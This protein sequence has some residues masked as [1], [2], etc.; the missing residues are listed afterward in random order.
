MKTKDTGKII[1]MW[2]AWAKKQGVLLNPDFD[3]EKKAKLYLKTNGKCFCDPKRKGPCLQS[4]EEI[5]K[6]NACLCS[7]FV[8]K[9][10]KKEGLKNIGK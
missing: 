10:F 9:K 5:K 6:H 8:N 7:L 1:R 4:I 3:L 2:K